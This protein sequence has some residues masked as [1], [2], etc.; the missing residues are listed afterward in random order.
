[1]LIAF[2]VGPCVLPISLVASVD[3]VKWLGYLIP[4]KY[5][6]SS[7]IEAFTS[8]L[9]HS[10][11]NLNSSNVWDIHSQYV[12]INILYTFNPTKGD[13][14]ITV[15]D[16]VDKVLNLVLPW[17][18]NL[19]FLYFVAATFRWNNRGSVKWRWDVFTQFIHHIKEEK[20]LTQHQQHS[21]GNVNS[22][23]ILEVKN[24]TRKFK[25]KN[26]VLV[27]NDD[28]S[29]NLVR[30]RNLAILGHNGAGKSVLVETIVGVTPPQEGNIVYNFEYKKSFNEK[31][32][33]QFQDSSYPYGIRVKDII[34]FFIKSYKLVISD[35]ELQE[36]VKKFG[37]DSFFNKNAGSLSGGQQQRVNL[38]LSVIHRPKVLFLD[39]LSTGLDIKIRNEIKDFIKD[40]AKKNDMTL[41]IVSHDMGEVDYLADDILILKNGQIQYFGTKKEIKKKYH[42]LEDFV[43]K[44]L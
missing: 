40:Y 26:G 7:A 23:N 42:S 22:K 43:Y 4:L 27:A 24:I 16:P 18:F 1:M 3:V 19:I 30:G 31:I 10:M 37:V 34:S 32:G 25:N 28:I 15:F 8:R 13:L 20:Q 29:F 39:E 14:K 44:Y 6:I 36:L 2:F 38:L 12:V 11:L 5:P 17:V 35:E 21:G 41:V 9:D 33:I